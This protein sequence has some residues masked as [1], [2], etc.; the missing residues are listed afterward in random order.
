MARNRVSALS[1]FRHLED[2]RRTFWAVMRISQHRLKPWW[3]Q[4]QRE[5]VSWV[6]LIFTIRCSVITKLKWLFSNSSR[7]LESGQQPSSPSHLIKMT[8]SRNQTLPV[9][10]VHC[11]SELRFYSP[12]H[13]SPIG[14]WL[15]TEV[16]TRITIYQMTIL[17]HV[18]R[19]IMF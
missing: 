11:C 14:E 7:I 16:D 15:L 4:A 2:G 6:T 9:V 1:L 19:H 17:V 5:W 10:P 13:C 8:V 3:Y 18:A 12:G